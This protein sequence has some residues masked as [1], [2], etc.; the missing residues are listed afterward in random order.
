MDV[1][2]VVCSCIDDGGDSQNG[3][4]EA[5]IGI[6]VVNSVSPS[7]DFYLPFALA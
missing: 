2:N 1:L 6:T 4:V 5:E 7:V 3:K